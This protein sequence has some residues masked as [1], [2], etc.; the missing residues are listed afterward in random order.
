MDNEEINNSPELR[1]SDH[2]GSPASVW[3]YL[4]SLIQKP[5]NSLSLDHLD[6]KVDLFEGLNTRNKMNI[7]HR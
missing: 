4:S 1:K 6:D 5:C 3:L 2:S 7:D